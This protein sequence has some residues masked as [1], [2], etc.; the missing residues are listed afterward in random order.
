MKKKI[1]E[2]LEYL[3][4]LNSEL[5]SFYRNDFDETEKSIIAERRM[6][7]SMEIGFLESLLDI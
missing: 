1:E 6:Q 4:E 3:K 2:R 7:I 5:I